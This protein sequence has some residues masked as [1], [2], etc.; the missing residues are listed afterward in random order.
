MIRIPLTTGRMSWPGGP[1]DCLGLLRSDSR[2]PPLNFPF[3]LS[4][5]HH[6][7]RSP[8]SLPALI[9][10][11]ASFLRPLARSCV[12]TAS[13]IASTPFAAPPRA[14]FAPLTLARAK[15]SHI[16]ACAINL[17]LLASSPFQ[18]YLNSGRGQAKRM[19]KRKR[20][21]SVSQLGPVLTSSRSLSRACPTPT[22][23]MVVM[24][25]PSHPLHLGPRVDD[26]RLAHW[27]RDRR[28]H[29]LRPEGARRR[30]FRRTPDC[31]HRHHQ[32]R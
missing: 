6:L 16:C 21:H 17:P 3:L 31:G 8:P 24:C 18:V 27:H 7:L 15:S 14:L 23:P 11:M 1:L 22:T 28:R 4:L 20:A 26:P 10:A 30:R 13:P 25:S 19:P 12:R 29:R 32:G 9:V 2:S 5:N